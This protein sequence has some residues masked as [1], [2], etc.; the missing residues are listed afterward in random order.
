M[1][2]YED[3]P[4]EPYD[5]DDVY[6]D[7]DYSDE[8]TTLE[9]VSLYGLPIY[10][11]PGP[12]EA[13]AVVVMVKGYWGDSEQPSILFRASGNLAPWEIQAILTEGIKETLELE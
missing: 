8:D 5:L 3:D 1:E 7:M 11:V 4:Q 12:F 6:G 10:D 2:F 13:T 9:E